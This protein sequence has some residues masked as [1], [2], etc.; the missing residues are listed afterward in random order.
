MA[1]I[2]L[3]SSVVLL[4]T[5]AAFFAYEFVTFRQTTIRHL[6]TL[7]EIIAANS[8]AA[9]AFE[10]Q[11]DANEVLAALQAERHVV[12]AALYDNA[13]KVFARYPQDLATSALPIAAGKPGYRFE[14][15]HFTAFQ[16]VV[17]RQKRLGSV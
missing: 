3:T 17:Q 10:N 12:A 6:S 8:T 14:H 4:V 1:I 16:P 2:L 9:L 15:A 5:C 11:G 13:G 7:G